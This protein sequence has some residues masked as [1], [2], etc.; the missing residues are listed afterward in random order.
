MKTRFIFRLVTLSSML[1]T[2]P[3]ALRAQAAAASAAAKPGAPEVLSSSLL[4]RPVAWV[5]SLFKAEHG[6]NAIGHFVAAGLLFLAA[7][8]LRKIITHVIFAW[9]KKLAAK[10]TTTLDDKLF[11]AVE[12]PV[13][14]LVFVFLIF[15]GLKVLVLPAW[16]DRWIGYAFDVAWIAVLFWGLL[17][18]LNAVVDHFSAVGRENGLGLSHFMPL[19]KKT[20][21]VVFII[22][23]TLT[24]AQRMGI[25]VGAFLTGLGLG[26]LAFALAAQDTIS[27][28]FASLVVVMDRPFQV[29]EYVSIGSAEGT[30]EDIGLRST[31]LRTG[32]RTQITIPNKMVANEIVTNFSRMPQRRVDQKFGLTYNTTPAKLEALLEDV[33]G[34]LRGDP[35][36]HQEFIAVNFTGYSESSLDIQLVY[37]SANPDWKKHMELRERINLQIMRAVAA[38]GLS[39]AFPTQTLHVEDEVARKLTGVKPAVLG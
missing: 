22:M 30:V 31:R 39:F 23:A 26:G 19:I 18:A 27:N 38:R 17:R 7:V 33:R 37:F 16:A 14:W 36:V 21:G 35:G 3:P 2:L 34:I 12:A 15:A 11:P 25:N 8:L 6:G 32:A 1:A 10:T 28:F 9:L 4:D 20:L 24:V 29:G 5:E 13:A